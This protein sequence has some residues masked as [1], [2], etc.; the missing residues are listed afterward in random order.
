MSGLWYKTSNNSGRPSYIYFNYADKEVILLSDE[1]EG[2]YSWEDSS[3]R[4]SGIYLTTVNSII[5]SMKRRFDIM[6]SGVNEAYIHVKDDVGNMV[7]KESNQW[8]G[9]YK[10]M[11][12]QNVFGEDKSI[13]VSDEYLKILTENKIWLDES[14]NKF[15]F[16][17]NSYKILSETG[18]E[19][20]LFA[21]DTAGSYPVIQ[22]RTLS[23]KSTLSKAYAMKFR[24]EEITIPSKKR[25]QKPTIEVYVHKD[26]IIFTPVRLSPDTVYAAEGKIFVL[27]KE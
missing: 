2:V 19:E 3:L 26:E 8:D 6:L 4:R 9:T 16:N 17:K 23:Q 20:G 11:S 22:F 13:P 24:T 14:G 10:K 5:S 15:T 18:V 25:N 12:F 21:V 7:I 27:K 1:T